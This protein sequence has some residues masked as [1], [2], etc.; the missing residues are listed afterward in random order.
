MASKRVQSHTYNSQTC[1]SACQQNSVA[2][3]RAEWTPRH[4]GFDCGLFIICKLVSDRAV[5]ACFLC[6]VWHVPPWQGEP[7]A[8]VHVIKGIQGIRPED[9]AAHALSHK[10]THKYKQA[11]V[12]VAGILC[13]SRKLKSQ[14]CLSF[15]YF[16]YVQNSIIINCCIVL[17]TKLGG[18][19]KV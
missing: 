15:D 2:H 19:I 7:H 11:Q 3:S 5:K 8:C 4:M 6:G 16:C 13:L 14:S 9:R 1:G 18:H 12:I 17:N 10:D